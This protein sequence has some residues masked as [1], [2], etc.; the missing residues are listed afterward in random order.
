MERWK[1][2]APFLKDLELE[3]LHSKNGNV[4]GACSNFGHVNWSSSKSNGSAKALPLTNWR[5]VYWV[6]LY[7]IWTVIPSILS[8]LLKQLVHWTRLL[9]HRMRCKFKPHQPTILVSNAQYNSWWPIW[10]STKKKA[11]RIRK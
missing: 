7:V 2:T 8:E 6:A 5:W 3:Q 11:N 4:K 9:C 1:R 10:V